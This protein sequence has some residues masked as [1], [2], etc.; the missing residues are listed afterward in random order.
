MDYKGRTVLSDPQNAGGIA[1]KGYATIDADRIGTYVEIVGVPGVD[2]DINFT[3]PAYENSVWK[4]SLTDDLWWCLENTDGAAEWTRLVTETPAGVVAV[5]GVMTP[6]SF[7]NAQVKVVPLGGTIQGTIDSIGDAATDKRYIVFVPAGT[8]TEQVTLIDYVSLQGAGTGVTIITNDVDTDD[9]V[10]TGTV[11]LANEVTISDMTIQATGTTLDDAAVGIISTGNGD[12]Y[13]IHN[14]EFD[15][16]WDM[17]YI[18]HTTSIGY[19]WDCSGTTEFDAFALD[20][21]TDAQ[22][23]ANS[24]MYIYNCHIVL[25]STR[26]FNVRGFA[27]SDGEATA[28]HYIYGCTWRG[29]TTS[30]AGVVSALYN[31]GIMRVY[32]SDLTATANN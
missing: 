20:G 4:N 27:N 1:V 17:V 28:G 32:N 19:I 23:T 31:E 11:L 6:E 25:A 14:V 2:Q 22:D 29:S 30:N 5:T 3:E 15:V 12:T 8:W 16:V 13:R 21:F 18:K 10:Q 9:K 26:N 24:A 7:G